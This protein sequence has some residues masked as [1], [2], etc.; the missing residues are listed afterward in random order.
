MVA[1]YIFANDLHRKHTI[2]A[3]R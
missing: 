1:L 2:K 3:K